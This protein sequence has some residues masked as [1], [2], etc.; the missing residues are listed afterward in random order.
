MERKITN[1][2]C[3]QFNTLRQNNQGIK[4]SNKELSI[5]MSQIFGVSPSTI[6]TDY[7]PKLVK[8]GALEYPKRGEYYFTS[9]PVHIEKLRNVF[10]TARK[11]KGNPKTKMLFEEA[12][13]I[14]KG[15][16]CKVLQSPPIIQIPVE[17]ILKNKDRRVGDFLT[18]EEI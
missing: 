3:A 15:Y 10:K 9:D 2:M 12:L 11:R 5:L 13:A 18:Y 17:E 1:D 16:H 4:Q 6:M 8:Y 14:V 7:L